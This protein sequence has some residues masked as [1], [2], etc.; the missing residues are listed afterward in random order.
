MDIEA[1][2]ALS[3]TRNLSYQQIG[4]CSFLRA[5]SL[6][7]IH[8]EPSSHRWLQVWHA[9][10]RPC[11]LNK[12]FRSIFIPVGLCQNE[13]RTLLNRL[14]EDGKQICA[15]HQLQHSKIKFIWR[16]K[17]INGGKCWRL[18]DISENAGS[19]IASNK[20]RVV[21]SWKTNWRHYLEVTY[22]LHEYHSSEPQLLLT[23]WLWHLYWFKS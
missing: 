14:I 5:Y 2:R 19:K 3:R 20:Y 18:K 16:T 11:N 15:S 9:H 4:R 12:S 1:C 17:T 23:F 7:K 21:S 13:Y 8:N 10:L 22:C 6:A